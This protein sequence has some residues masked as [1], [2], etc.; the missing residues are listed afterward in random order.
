MMVRRLHII[1]NFYLLIYFIYLFV[2]YFLI[3]LTQYLQFYSVKF[4]AFLLSSLQS[5]NI[6]SCCKQPITIN[7]VYFE[8]YI[9]KIS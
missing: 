6:V 2:Y 3:I 5:R 4:Y 8:F 7:S 1:I 9:W